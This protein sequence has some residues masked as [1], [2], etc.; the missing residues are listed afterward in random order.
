M[1]QILN[2]S[3]GSANDKIKA[4][5]RL[6][7]KFDNNS[8][9]LYT[10]ETKIMGVEDRITR[11]YLG[12]LLLM[13]ASNHLI[14]PDKMGNPMQS[15]NGVTVFNGSRE[16]Q[17]ILEVG[18]GGWDAFKF[19]I[20][21]TTFLY[22]F[23]CKNFRDLLNGSKQIDPMINSI[24]YKFFKNPDVREQFNRVLNEARINIKEN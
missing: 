15:S 2:L 4:V 5:E 21:N 22:A 19:W 24:F 11:I 9:T 23:R 14:V 10:M 3:E 1:V 16:Q 7:D 13:H 8:F 12:D 17:R 18:I 20:S 6:R